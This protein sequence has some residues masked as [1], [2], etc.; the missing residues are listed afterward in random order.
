MT[1]KSI[2]TSILV[3]AFVLCFCLAIPAQ[4]KKGTAAPVQS[5]AS[6]AKKS[7]D[8][9]KD[10]A[11]KLLNP[12]EK[13]H[14]SPIQ[15]KK[16][17]HVH[18]EL[19]GIEAEGATFVYVFDRSA[20]MSEPKNRPINAA[21]EELLKSL[22]PMERVHQFYIVF[23]N[24][25]PRMFQPGGEKGK[26]VFANDDNKE[27]AKKFVNAIAP[28]GGTNHRAALDVALKIRP[29]VI[30]LLTDGDAEDDLTAHD[31][32]RID[33][34]NNGISQIHVIQFKGDFPTGPNLQK[35]AKE[36]RGEF[37]SVKV[38]DLMKKINDAK[39]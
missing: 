4:E 10:E 20:S 35:L 8:D 32:E 15:A 23:Y 2:L 19:F 27:A 36:N 31:L 38:G 26:L 24:E 17:G 21:K 6:P 39:K 14:R 9:A 22:E 11:L 16:L 34:V 33:K 30:F 7:A 3:A 1:I 13:I 37:K 29:D 12:D 28:E 25:A 18:T 5:N